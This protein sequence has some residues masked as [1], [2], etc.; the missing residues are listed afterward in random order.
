MTETRTVFT[1]EAVNALVPRLQSLV[2]AQMGRRRE[3]EERV[4]ELGKLVHDASPS[5]S[6][7]E[8]DTTQVRGLK[9]DLQLRIG[10]YQDAWREVESM[11]AVLKDPRTGLLDFYGQVDGKLVWLC[12]RYGEDAVTHYHALDEGF[13][14]RKPIE[15]TMRNRHLN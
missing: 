10:R 11:G 8:A 1:L 13:G 5:L 3:I 6:L 14:G 4:V 2:S 12:W 7:A 9:Q 15:P